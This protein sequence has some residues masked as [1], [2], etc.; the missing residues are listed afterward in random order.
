MR[1]WTWLMC[2]GLIVAPVAAVLAGDS[3]EPY[4]SCHEEPSPAQR[5]AAQGAF[6]AGSGSY[7]EGDYT[8]AIEYWR[9]AYRRD[10]TA[11]LLL[12]NLANAYERLGDR[13]A[14]VFALKTYLERQKDI[15]DRSILERRVQNLEEQIAA[16]QAASAKAAT[17]AAASSSAPSSSSKPPPSPPVETSRAGK[18]ITPWIVVGAG[19]VITV[20][21]ALVYAGGNTKVKDAEAACPNHQCTDPSVQASGND[22]RTQM[23]VGGA[24]IG[25][26]LVGVAGGLVWHYV[27]DKPSQSTAASTSPLLQPALGPGYAGMSYGGSF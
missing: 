16:A 10:C 8:K 6:Q 4:P 11:H 7:Q 14:A 21:G 13:R 25:I 12:L 27:L 17:A 3:M 22:G 18:S 15:Q 20:V 24:M 2:G 19:G 23:N 1:R 9:D 26:G 5:Q